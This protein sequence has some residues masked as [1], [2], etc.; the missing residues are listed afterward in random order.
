MEIMQQQMAQE[1]LCEDARQNDVEEER[2]FLREQ[3]RLRQEEDSRSRIAMNE[4][5]ATALSAF[6]AFA[7]ARINHDEE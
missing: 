5:I 2:R 3:S 1:Q 6:A 4:S 7:A